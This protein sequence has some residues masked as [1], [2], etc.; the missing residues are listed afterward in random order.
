MIFDYISAS[1]YIYEMLPFYNKYFVQC[2]M[3]SGLIWG[4]G[5]SRISLVIGC[6]RNFF[7]GKKS[8]QNGGTSISRKNE[9]F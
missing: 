5:F 8:R 6:C 4:V 2:S 9:N 1:L 7:V 3:Q